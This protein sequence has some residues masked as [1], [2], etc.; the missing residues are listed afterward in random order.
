MNPYMKKIYLEHLI[1][2][3]SVSVF[4]MAQMFKYMLEGQPTSYYYDL[5]FNLNL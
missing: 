3:K 2:K 4:I 5:Y 1:N